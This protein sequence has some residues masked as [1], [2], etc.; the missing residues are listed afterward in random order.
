MSEIKQTVPQDS[1]VR[2]TIRRAAE[3]M[4]RSSELK[5]PLDLTHLKRHAAAPTASLELD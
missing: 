4:V 5:P 2:E 1:E 3:D